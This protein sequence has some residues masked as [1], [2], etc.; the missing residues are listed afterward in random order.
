[1]FF[2]I[3][4]LGSLLLEGHFTEAAAFTTTP[5]TVVQQQISKADPIQSSTFASQ[6]H[7]TSV[8]LQSLSTVAPTSLPPIPRVTS[9]PSLQNLELRQRCWNDQ[10]FSIDCAVWTGYRYS[11]G[12]SSNPYDYWSGGGPG[13]GGGVALSSDA[14]KAWPVRSHVAILLATSIGLWLSGMI[15]SC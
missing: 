4:V 6:N 2:Y 14:S 7:L 13:S 15:F 10:G 8:T 1:M 9:P 12:P 11:W 5:V 3:L